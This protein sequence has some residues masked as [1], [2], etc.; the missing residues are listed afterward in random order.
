[1][2]NG[3]HRRVGLDGLELFDERLSQHRAATGQARGAQITLV[4]R[5]VNPRLLGEIQQRQARRLVVACTNLLID[6]LTR[7]GRQAQAVKPVGDVDLIQ[8]K[9]CA[10]GRR[11]LRVING[12]RQIVQR[13]VVALDGFSGCGLFDRQI[14]LGEV[15]A[16]DQVAGRAHKFR[17]GHGRQ[18][19]TVQVAVQHRLGLGIADPLAGGQTGATTQRRFGLQQRHLPALGLQLIGSG[20]ARQAT[21]DDDRRALFFIGERRNADQPCNYQRTRAQP[22]RK[23]SAN[24]EKT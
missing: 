3:R 17:R 1:M 10:V 13:L 11:V 23:H 18:L 6:Q 7:R 24:S 21:A 20:Q 8:G 14:S 15:N 12:A 9:Q 19:E 16:V 5:T 22:P 4:N 2:N